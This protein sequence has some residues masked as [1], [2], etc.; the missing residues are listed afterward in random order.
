MCVTCNKFPKRGINKKIGYV[1]PI[2]QEVFRG[3]IC[4]TFGT[5]VWIAYDKLFG[6]WLRDV[7]SVW[8]HIWS[9]PVDKPSCYQLRAGATM[10]YVMN[11]RA[12]DVGCFVFASNSTSLLTT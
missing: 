10:Q 3:R 12:S 8:G 5:A 1:S 7:D 2:C 9:F 6:S 4:T 11:A